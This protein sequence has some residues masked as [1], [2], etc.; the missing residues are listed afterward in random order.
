MEHGGPKVGFL[1]HFIARFSWAIV[2]QPHAEQV[3]V[4]ARPRRVRSTPGGAA[5]TFCSTDSLTKKKGLI[6]AADGKPPESNGGRDGHHPDE[7]MTPISAG[8]T[9]SKP[10]KAAG[11]WPPRGVDR[12]ALTPTP[13]LSI[14]YTPISCYSTARLP[15]TQIQPPGGPAGPAERRP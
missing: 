10:R 11:E 1:F 6:G 3:S 9:V 8:P 4:R 15:T 5:F 13:S 2:R 12:Q 14:A 7:F